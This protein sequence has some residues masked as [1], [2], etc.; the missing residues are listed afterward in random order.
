MS[1]GPCRWDWSDINREN[2]NEVFNMNVTSV[3]H[4]TRA[5]LPLLRRGEKKVNVNMYVPPL[6][7]GKE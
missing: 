3:H 5:F 6:E 4:V 2:L 1:Q 7:N